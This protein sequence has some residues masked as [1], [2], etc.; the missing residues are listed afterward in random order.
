VGIRNAETA[1]ALHNL[2]FPINKI[3]P[4]SQN[5]F[6]RATFILYLSSL[7]VKS[8]SASWRTND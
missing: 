8:Q 1:R 4:E 6:S 3:V 5:N 7:L 2:G